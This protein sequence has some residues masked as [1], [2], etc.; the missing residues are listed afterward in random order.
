VIQGLYADEAKIYEER[1][2][3]PAA[4]IRANLA[5]LRDDE[6]LDQAASRM[7]SAARDDF[8]TSETLAFQYRSALKQADADQLKETIGRALTLLDKAAPGLSGASSDLL[9]KTVQA[10]AAW[11]DGFG[12]AT[13]VAQTRI[14]RLG[15]WTVKEGEV[16]TA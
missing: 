1:L 16:M 15:T 2:I 12:E 5:K 4:A 14:T 11:R 6:A 8:M 9:K 13:K 10:I 7:I 3:A